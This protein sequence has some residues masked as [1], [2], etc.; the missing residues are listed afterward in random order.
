MG[1]Q[2]K[3]YSSLGK[4]V[5]QEYTIIPYAGISPRSP[6]MF[7][8]IHELDI[9]VSSFEQTLNPNWSASVDVYIKD[10]QSLINGEPRKYYL[11]NNLILQ[12]G[13]RWHNE[14]AIG[15]TSYQ[16]L[17]YSI[18]SM[19]SVASGADDY[20]VQITTSSI[21]FLDPSVNLYTITIN[22]TPTDASVLLDYYGS[23]TTSG[24]IIVP[25]GNSA[26]YTVSARHYI[27][28]S[29]TVIA[30]ADKTI[31]VPLTKLKCFKVSTNAPNAPITLSATNSQGVPVIDGF[32]QEGDEIWVTPGTVVT[33][34]VTAPHYYP[35]INQTY[36]VSDDI[37]F[38][39]IL[40]LERHT[41][42]VST[43][44]VDANVQ[45]IL[46]GYSQSGNTIVV[47]WGS[48]V[49]CV[50][51]KDPYIQS[52]S[53]IKVLENMSQFIALD[54][55]VGSSLLNTNEAKTHPVAI[56]KP[57]RIE[58]WLV[59]GG[60]GGRN[61]TWIWTSGTWG[62]QNSGGGGGAFAHGFIDITEPGTY[63]VVVGAGGAGGANNGGNTSGFGE[64]AG[65]GQFGAQGFLYANGGVGGTVSVVKLSGQ[66][67]NNGTGCVTGFTGGN[68][69]MAGGAS[70]YNGHGAGGMSKNRAGTN[71]YARVDYISPLA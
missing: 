52:T 18:K 39:V 59:G 49:K 67:G 26:T 70:L 41:L 58:V 3:N 46:E 42:S 32:V 27:V 36:T 1:T 17:C 5:N 35:I 23:T 21:E 37:V 13:E 2:Y 38:P 40:E 71:G 7:N 44:P 28:E 54:M 20:N 50:V 65:G 16:K 69:D 19:T 48:T 24:F 68:P 34:S 61:N 56:T 55:R 11:Y 12:D 60:A 8:E 4:V 6:A 30:D 47:P 14:K 31:D 33:Y 43:L 45:L 25:E 9:C 66:N 63:N 64:T 62:W 22:P 53:Y 29:Q 51:S 15:L 10:S 57:A